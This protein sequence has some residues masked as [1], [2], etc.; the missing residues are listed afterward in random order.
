MT[1]QR[2][3]TSAPDEWTKPRP[4]LDPSTRLYRHG[5]IRP[6]EETSLT[7]RLRDLMGDMMRRI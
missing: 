7:A 3:H 1:F 6:L 4:H 2:F 5:P